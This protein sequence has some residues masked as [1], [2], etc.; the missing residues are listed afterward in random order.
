MASL[1][2][3][4]NRDGSASW[5]AT[6]R[7]V[8]YPTA[9]KTF[10]T[11][12]EADLWASRIEAAARGRT[13]T[14]ARGLTLAQ[15]IDEAL[16]KVDRPVSAAFAYWRAQLGFLRLIDVTPQLIALHRDRLLGAPCRGFNNKTCKPRSNATVRTYLLD[17]RKHE[18]L[19]GMVNYV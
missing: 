17:T 8:G 18:I 7:V 12:L 5:D 14:L 2:R 19:L 11:K 15:L 6:V 10:S 13:L 16:P 3:R 9:C 1:T 4:R